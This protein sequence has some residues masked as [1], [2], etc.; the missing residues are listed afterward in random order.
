MESP[1]FRLRLREIK[2]RQNFKEF[3]SRHFS[4]RLSPFVAAA[5]FN[6]KVTPNHLTLLMIP[7]G[8]I[9]AALFMTGEPW[10]F[11]LGGL[12]FVLLNILDAAD[13]E[14]ARYRNTTSLFGDYLDRVAHYAT[15]SAAV[16]GL[17]IGLWVRTDSWIPLAAM[18]ILELAIVMDEAIRDLLITCGVVRIGADEGERK[19]SKAST[20]LHAGKLFGTAFNVLFTNVALFHIVPVLG[21]VDWFG[22]AWFGAPLILGYY[23]AFTAAAFAK[24]SARA[25]SMAKFSRARAPE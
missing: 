22:P 21:L 9:G 24:V 25:V 13:G 6:T 19:K 5:L 12:F 11:F 4:G 17:G 16:L 3:Y 18:V 1:G 23:L 14:L 15:N 20:K 8:F 2:A 7:S 10:G